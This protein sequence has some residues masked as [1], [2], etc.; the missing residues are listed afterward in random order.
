MSSAIA[1][2]QNSGSVAAHSPQASSPLAEAQSAL[3]R[4]EVNKAVTILSNYLQ[5]HPKNVPAR[6]A[7]GQAYVSA[8]QNEQ[9]Q[10]EL[11]KVLK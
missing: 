11:Q 10:A 4:G 8:G 6:L 3:E 9:A 5:G 1:E 2:H 7:L